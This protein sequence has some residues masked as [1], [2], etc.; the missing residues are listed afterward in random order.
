M[1]EA[2]HHKPCTG[3]RNQQEKARRRRI[4]S[5]AIVATAGRLIIV[6]THWWPRVIF[7]YRK[8][9][10]NELIWHSCKSRTAAHSRVFYVFVAGA[11][12]CYTPHDSLQRRLLLSMWYQGKTEFI[13]PLERKSQGRPR[14]SWCCC[15]RILVPEAMARNL[16]MA[17]EASWS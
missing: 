1:L 17:A 8:P 15:G 3:A 16:Q 2:V 14:L 5:R 7:I 10:R 9:P 6:A 4:D 13:T 11:R 12:I